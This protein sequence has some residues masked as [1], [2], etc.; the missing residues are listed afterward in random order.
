MATSR[1]RGDRFEFCIRRKGVLPKPVWLSFKTQE[2]G[3]TYC[4]RIERLLDAGVIPEELSN[5]AQTLT[6]I[7]LAQEHYE[8]HSP[9]SAADASY[10]PVIL[11]RWGAARISAV[12][13]AWVENQIDRCKTEWHLAP[14]TI[15]HQM[16]AMAR[17]W[18]WLLKRSAVATNPFRA[19]RRGYASGERKDVERERRIERL[20][21]VRLICELDGDLLQMFVLALET[22]MRMREI[23][24]LTTEQVDLKKRTIFLD[25]TKNGD[26]R[27][28]PLSSTAVIL[29]RPLVKKKGAALFANE[30]T[31]RQVTSRYSVAFGRAAE[32]A[33][34][35]DIHF[36]D[37]RHEATCRLFERTKLDWLEI[38]KITGHRDP[39]MLRRYANLRGSDLAARLW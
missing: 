2:E 23:Y 39:R 19:L 27:Q 35:P 14:A 32:R 38:S 3:D 22:A 28:V 13:F 24:T 15:R 9:V 21:E 33:G 26:S 5:R 30:G 7:A 11:K 31:P 20:E 1:Q 4:A 16:G 10:W 29:L 37:T 17:L 36:H 25:K 34:C 6:T 12:D 8:R 18:D